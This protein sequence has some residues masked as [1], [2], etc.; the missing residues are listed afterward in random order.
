[1]IL[2]RREIFALKA[3]ALLL[4]F[5]AGGAKGDWVEKSARVSGTATPGLVHRIITV[6][7][8]S[9]ETAEVDLAVFNFRRSALRLRLIDNPD[10]ALDLSEAMA[11]SNCLAGTNGGY[12][13]PEFEPMGLR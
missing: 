12:F 10:R 7:S 6:E 5:F 3:A 11:G 9:G 2:L 8:S 4:L 13:D 1:M